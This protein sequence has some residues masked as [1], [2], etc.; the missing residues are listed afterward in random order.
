MQMLIGELQLFGVFHFLRFIK[1]IIIMPIPIILGAAALATAA[2]GAKKGY[3]GYQKHSE[4]DDTVNSAKR[5]YEETRAPFD[6]QEKATN[7]VLDVLGQEELKIGQQFNEF[8]ALA[9]DILQKLNSGRQNKLEISI[10]KHKLQK[11][12]GYSYT[13]IG[14]LGAAAGAGAAGAAA[15]FA[16]YGGVMA[17][18]AASTG[19]SISA[20][21]G[22]AATNATL[23]AIGGGSLAT[24][25][26]G[27]A[28][29]SAILG[30]AVA[31]PV[32]AIAGWAYNSHGEEAIKNANKINSQVGSAIAKLK[33]AQEQLSNTEDYAF[34]IIEVLKAVYAQFDQY[35]DILKAVTRQIEAAKVLKQDPQVAL[36]QLSDTIMR[37]IGN[38][39][40]LAAILV[41]LITTPLFRVKHANGEIQKDTN[42]V[43]VMDTDEDGSMILN[44]DQLDKQLCDTKTSAAR[45]EPA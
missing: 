28:G 5:R 22:V 15:G 14:V 7:D 36:A 16:I 6:I 13:A 11:I 41:D 23:A 26:L 25:G 9:D 45:I 30:A 42:G 2:Y 8:K 40:A 18:G 43:P 20:L 3:D 44:T 19:I 31:G 37:A 35:F 24:G 10:P 32:L 34:E 38:G 17:L 33:K 39:Y 12:E 1:G 4:A 27:M 29:G 21:S